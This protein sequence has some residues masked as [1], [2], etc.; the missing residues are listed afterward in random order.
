MKWTLALSLCLMLQWTFAQNVSIEKHPDTEMYTYQEVIP[1]E[2][3]TA[4]DGFEKASYWI[5]KNYKLLN[6][7]V[8]V[9]EV[10]RKEII[11]DS[12]FSLNWI[13]QNGEISHKLILEFREGRIRITASHFSFFTFES[14]DEPFEGM[15]FKKALMQRT[16]K[17]LETILHSLTDEIAGIPS[18]ED[19]W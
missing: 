7:V 9:D 8:K 11:F 2:N 5:A 14:G 6:E 3:M 17:K 19:D 18:P 12:F 4:Q 10:D 15:I 13:M 1:L 16:E